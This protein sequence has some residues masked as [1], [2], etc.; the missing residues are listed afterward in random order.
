L[1]EPELVAAAWQAREKASAP[2]SQYRVGAALL[3]E[4]GRVFMGSNVESSTYGL[5]ICAE[6]VALFKALS[7]GER[8][9]F[10][11]IAVAAEGPIAPSPCGACRQLMAD[12]APNVDFLLSGQP[13]QFESVPL[14]ALLPRPFTSDYL[15]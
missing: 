6:R 15:K 8:G 2:Y 9:P 10:V 13:G 1:T 4:S 12:Y 5:S 3:S 11:K 14:S 7:E